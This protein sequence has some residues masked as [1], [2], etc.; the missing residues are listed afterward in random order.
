MTPPEHITRGL[1]LPEG[2]DGVWHAC[3]GIWFWLPNDAT[4]AEIWRAA[5]QLEAFALDRPASLLS[6]A[7]GE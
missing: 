4:D 3:C 5:R 6:E 2:Q 7:Q 1:P